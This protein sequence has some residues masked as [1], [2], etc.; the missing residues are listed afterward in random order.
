MCGC[1]AATAVEG[2]G[3]RRGS[4]VVC[5]ASWY[6]EESGAAGRTAWVAAASFF[7][8]SPFRATRPDTPLM[9]VGWDARGMC[10]LPIRG[11]RAS[12]PC[13]RFFRWE[14][15]SVAGQRRRATT[16]ADEHRGGVW[17]RASPSHGWAWV[18]PPGEVVCHFGEGGGLE[19]TSRWGRPP[20]AASSTAEGFGG[21]VYKS[22]GSPPPS[23]SRPWT[24]LA[25]CAHPPHPAVDAAGF[26]GGHPP[27]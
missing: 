4:P 2:G 10:P 8:P 21:P 14:G 24:T 16:S 6:W 27:W 20:A 9:G 15:V 5:V 13:A 17:R 25:H 7:F 23:D 1:R 19:A 26:G 12:P 22:N 18:S 11:G 3:E